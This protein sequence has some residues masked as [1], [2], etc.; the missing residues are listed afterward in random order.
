MKPVSN[1]EI[2]QKNAP[3]A[4]EVIIIN[5]TIPGKEVCKLKSQVTVGIYVKGGGSSVQG[6]ALEVG[7][8]SI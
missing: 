5:V 8:N 3:S 2:H 6:G 1:Q 4:E 7:F